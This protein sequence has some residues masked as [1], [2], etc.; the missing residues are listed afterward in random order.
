MGHA[1]VRSEEVLPESVNDASSIGH[2]KSGAIVS[3]VI[4]VFLMHPEL[5]DI[6]MIHSEYGRAHMANDSTIASEVFRAR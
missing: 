2:L 1:S 6:E 3:K 4:N 5:L